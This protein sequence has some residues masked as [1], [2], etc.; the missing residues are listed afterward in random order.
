MDGMYSETLAGLILDLLAGEPMSGF[1]LG[2]ALAKRHGITFPGGEG[3]LYAALV[4]MEKA[5]WIDGCWSEGEPGTR[6]RLYRLPV[7][8]PAGE[9]SE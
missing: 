5:G 4:Q 7:L 6:R 9:E 3:L 8:V 2:R 1:A